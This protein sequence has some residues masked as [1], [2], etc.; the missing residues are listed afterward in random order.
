M[1]WSYFFSPDYNFGSFANSILA[2]AKASPNKQQ[3]LNDFPALPDV[4]D[5]ILGHISITC[6]SNLQ[7]LILLDEIVMCSNP[8]S[9]ES[10][11]GL[12]SQ[13]CGQLLNMRKAYL[14]VTALNDME[15]KEDVTASNRPIQYVQ[16][17]KL[18]FDEM[19]LLFQTRIASIENANYNT[20]LKNELRSIVKLAFLY[21][22]GHPRSLV[23]FDVGISQY[24]YQFLTDTSEESHGTAFLN[25]L[26]TVADYMKNYQIPSIEMVALAIVGLKLPLDFEFYSN[27]NRYNLKDLV[28]K[29]VYLLSKDEDIDL[30]KSFIPFITFWRPQIIKFLEADALKSKNP[31]QVRLTKS[32]YYLY[33]TLKTKILEAAQSQGYS[34]EEFHFV[35]E[36]IKQQARIISHSCLSLKNLEDWKLIQPQPF[37]TNVSE[38]ASNSKKLKLDLPAALSLT[39]SE[40]YHLEPKQ[41]SEVSF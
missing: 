30:S 39:I 26:E 22:N 4:I 37:N 31:N 32:L 10:A 35:A 3:H 12:C 6:Q 19:K 33:N 34:F 27:S 8:K 16:I 15:N 13:L 38:P 21:S 9:K 28:E 41:N 1:I 40:H 7:L 29:G 18:I 23:A 20:G 11:F 25:V 24:L 5:L 2:C 36:V 17:H 14:V